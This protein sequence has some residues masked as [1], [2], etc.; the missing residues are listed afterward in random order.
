M[1]EGICSILNTELPSF[2]IWTNPIDQ[3]SVK[4]GGGPPLL[5]LDTNKIGQTSNG[6]N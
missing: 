2:K 4:I 6:T 3:K 1:K 5:F